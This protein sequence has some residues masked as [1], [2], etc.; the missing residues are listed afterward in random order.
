[1]SVNRHRERTE[2]LRRL[3]ALSRQRALSD[4]ESRQL[5]AVLHADYCA[6][7]RA[8]LPIHRGIIHEPAA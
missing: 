7:L 4:A 1:M 6:R 8:D 3:D 5:E 2:R